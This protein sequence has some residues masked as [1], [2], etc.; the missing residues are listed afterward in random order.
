MDFFPFAFLAFLAASAGC[1]AAFLARVDVA[2]TVPDALGSGSYSVTSSCDTYLG[3]TV[4]DAVPFVV[5]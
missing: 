5:L 1:F 4:F 2:V 3:S